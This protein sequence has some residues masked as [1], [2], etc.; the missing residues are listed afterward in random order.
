MSSSSS[1]VSRAWTPCSSLRICAPAAAEVVAQL[2]R[3]SNSLAVWA[4]SSSSSGSS[5][6]L[7]A[8]TV[9][10]DV[11]L[12]AGMLA[13]DQRGGEVADS[14]ADSPSSAS[15]RPSS[16][17]PLPTWYDRPVAVRVLDLLA[18]HVAATRSIDTKS[19]VGGG[20][21]D[22]GQRG[23]PLAQPVDL[24][25]DVVVGDVRR[26]RPSPRCPRRSGSSNSRTDVDLGGELQL[27]AVA[28]LGHVDLGLAERLDLVLLDGARRAAAAPR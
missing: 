8:V 19:P 14:P 26:R 5:R 6:S 22:A 23:E 24:L 21:L 17:V 15:S 20:T 28:E 27:A 13:A 12:L 9:T 4:K 7:T 18:V 25:V 2:V 16:R 3:V 1:T 10:V 11:G